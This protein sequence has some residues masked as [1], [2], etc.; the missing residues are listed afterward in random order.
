MLRLS[1]LVVIF[2]ALALLGGLLAGCGVDPMERL[3]QEI[4]VPDVAVRERAIHSLANLADSRATES[5]IEVL[6]SDEDMYDVAAVA[7]VKKGREVS[8]RRPSN[9]VV[10]KIIEILQKAHVGEPFRARAAWVLGEIGDRTAIPALK[11]AS[12][13]GVALSL[14]VDQA[15]YALEKLGYTNKGRGYEIPLG[16]LAGSVEVL[17]QIEPIPPIETENSS[18]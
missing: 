13:Y 12:G 14:V 4:E 6:E 16:T 8:S 1:R 11:T 10:E 17:P 9:P 15:N 7:L 18:A 3:G 2:S 5:L